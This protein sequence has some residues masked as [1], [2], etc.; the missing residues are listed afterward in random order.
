VTE[1][2]VGDAVGAAAAGR[3]NGRGRAAGAVPGLAIWLGSVVMGRLCPS[4]AVVSVSAPPGSGSMPPAGC[5][6]LAAGFQAR[7]R[8][9]RHWEV[10]RLLELAR[11]GPCRRHS[12]FPPIAG[13]EPVEPRHGRGGA[14]SVGELGG[15]AVHRV[16]EGLGREPPSRALPSAEQGGACPQHVVGQPSGLG[17]HPQ[18]SASPVDEPSALD[19]C[20]SLLDGCRFSAGGVSRSFRF[21]PQW[22]VPGTRYA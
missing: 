10:Q 9:V 11:R 13:L 18:V 8:H 1:P 6:R 14:V 19:V 12:R 21:H 4:A 17:C 15:V 16:A 2:H 7:L 22:P 3:Q 5:G 20:P